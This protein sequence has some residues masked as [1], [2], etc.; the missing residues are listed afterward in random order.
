MILFVIFR[1]VTFN[2]FL[3]LTFFNKRKGC[4]FVI[5]ENSDIESAID[6]IIEA[7]SSHRGMVCLILFNK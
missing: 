7:A 2:K 6:K 3:D 1:H 5:F 4:T